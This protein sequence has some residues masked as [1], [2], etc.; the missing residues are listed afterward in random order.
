MAGFRADNGVPR[1]PILSSRLLIATDK[2]GR[3]RLGNLRMVDCYQ[4][5]QE[6]T[7]NVLTIA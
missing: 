7:H 4:Q 6:G 3:L 2:R 1:P 5:D